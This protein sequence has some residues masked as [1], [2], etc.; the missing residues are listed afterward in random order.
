MKFKADENSHL[1][2]ERSSFSMSQL[3]KLA[4]MYFVNQETDDHKKV[5]D[6]GKYIVISQA[7]LVDEKH[8]Y[9]TKGTRLNEV[10]KTLNK[11]VMNPTNDQVHSLVEEK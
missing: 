1:R 8:G 2:T 11:K 3:Q 7:S 6:K 4:V 10:K 5:F 9:A